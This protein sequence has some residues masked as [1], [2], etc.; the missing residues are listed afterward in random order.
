V[1]VENGPGAAVGDRVMI[2]VPGGALLRATFQ[3]YMVPV[4]GI[5]AGAGFA[6]V[7]VQA[8]AGPRAAGMAAGLGGLAGGLLSIA[9]LRRMRRDR[10]VGADLRP[11]I[12]RII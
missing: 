10:P 8:V 6:Q 4:L 1:E 5:L 7:L 11:K 9:A 2:A 12:V 3:A